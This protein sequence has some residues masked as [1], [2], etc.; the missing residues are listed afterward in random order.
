MEITY[1]NGGTVINYNHSCAG[2][3]YYCEEEDIAPGDCK[4]LYRKSLTDST[5]LIWKW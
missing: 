4:W 2:N 1:T 3:C 5:I